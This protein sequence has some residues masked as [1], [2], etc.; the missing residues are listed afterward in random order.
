M[1]K[2]EEL[3]NQIDNISANSENEYFDA[4]RTLL[5][6]YTCEVA[7]IDEE[8]FEKAHKNVFQFL[9]ISS[10]AIKRNQEY[11]R[12]ITEKYQ[13]QPETPEPELRVGWEYQNGKGEWVEIKKLNP[14]LKDYPA[15]GNNGCRYT[16]GGKFVLWTV[17]D[18]RNLILS[19]GRQVS[20]QPSP[21][22]WESLKEGDLVVDDD[23]IIHEVKEVYKAT[24][25]EGY[26]VQTNLGGYVYVSHKY[27]PSSTEAIADLQA[28]KI[29]VEQFQKVYKG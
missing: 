14:D 19:T 8:V 4:Y 25:R 27:T 15:F 24:I 7:K 5:T 3:L 9:G 1:N 28:G 17:D 16:I 6:T 18:D 22:W 26:F 2:I 23:G 29:T 11:N 21:N 20:K 13:A 12:L 10:E